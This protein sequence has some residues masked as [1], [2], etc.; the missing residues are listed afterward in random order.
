MPVTLSGRII[1]DIDLAFINQLDL[2]QAVDAIK[3]KFAVELQTGTGVNQAQNI[4]HD[5]RTLSA[6]ANEDLDLAGGTLTNIFGTVL[7][8]TKLRALIVRARDTNSNNV[9]VKRPTT[10]GVP[11]FGAADDAI[12]V[13][14]G[15]IFCFVAPNN[16]GVP[17]TA[18]TADLINFANSAGG[19]TVTYDVIIVGV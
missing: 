11:L 14:P 2:S 19:S 1:V 18:T 13:V 3:A 6:N 12:S 15:G 5:T 17:I 9:V 8:M 10:N 7:T 16:A 4:F